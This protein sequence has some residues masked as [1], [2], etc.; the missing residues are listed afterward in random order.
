MCLYSLGREIERQLG[1]DP[2]VSHVV[3]LPFD[4]ICLE[5][6]LK[7]QG[8]FDVNKSGSVVAE[9]LRLP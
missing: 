9:H 3:K 2:G 4:Y 8:I 6:E 1:T 5:G 7:F